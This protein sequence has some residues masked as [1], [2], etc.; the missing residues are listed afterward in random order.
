M[1]VTTARRVS[2]LLNGIF[3]FM[4]GRRGRILYLNDTISRNAFLSSSVFSR[5]T[6]VGEDARVWRPPFKC[7]TFFVESVFAIVEGGGK[8]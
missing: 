4:G 3:V 8:Q 5:A 2:E 7:G 1:L 6:F